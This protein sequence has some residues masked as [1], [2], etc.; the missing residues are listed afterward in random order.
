MQFT[1]YN[2][3][4]GIYRVC[5]L[6]LTLFTHFKTNTKSIAIHRVLRCVFK[7]SKYIKSHEMGQA[8]QGSILLLPPP[9]LTKVLLW[10][11]QAR[12]SGLHFLQWTVALLQTDKKFSI[13]ALMQS[14]AENADRCVCSFHRDHSIHR[15][16]MIEHSTHL[17][18]VWNSFDKE[19]PLACQTTSPFNKKIGCF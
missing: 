3:R 8:N 16:S 5:I 18:V 4:D 10:L 13:S 17:L 1:R 19:Q 14:N 9:L 11:I 6:Y 12:H 2:Q 15:E 7:K